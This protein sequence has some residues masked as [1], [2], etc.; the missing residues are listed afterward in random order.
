MQD[1]EGLTDS[2]INIENEVQRLYQQIN[3]NDLNGC[4]QM[5]QTQ[6]NGTSASNHLQQSAVSAEDSNCYDDATNVR[7]GEDNQINQHH[8]LS[9]DCQQLSGIQGAGDI[10]DMKSQ[11]D[12]LLQG[13]MNKKD[14][15]IQQTVSK[16][17]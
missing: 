9:S 16:H 8:G 6:K 3:A 13:F 14:D 5:S 4:L 2:Q 7:N 11:F 17:N 15:L 12:Q 10:S 1:L